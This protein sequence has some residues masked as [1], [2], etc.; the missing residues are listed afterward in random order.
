[1]DL[2]LEA[3]EDVQPEIAE[4][5]KL[6]WE[7]IAL[8]KD[9][10]LAPDWDAYARLDDAGMLRPYVARNEGGELVGYSV[11][12]VS[13]AM[14]YRHSLQANQDVVFL[15]P[16]YRRGRLGMSL[17][18]LAEDS[19]RAEGV[20]VIHHHVKQAHPALGRVLERMGYGV[21]DI[22]YKKRLDK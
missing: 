5:C 16:D 15:H 13:P 20:Q 12:F 11:F 21:A 18:T 2:A 3:W 19:L 22:I 17:L 6:H 1:M 9:I 4:L 10:P 7:E 8:D 14:H